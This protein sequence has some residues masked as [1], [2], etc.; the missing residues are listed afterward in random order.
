MNEIS[1]WLLKG[2][3]AIRYMAQRDLLGADAPTLAAL[4]SQIAFEG[5]G[6]A[7]LSRQNE[8]GHWGLHYYQ[9]KWTSTHYTL[10]DIKNLG[11][12]ATQRACVNIVARM[13]DECMDESGGLNLAKHEHLSD[14]CVDGMIL[15]YAAYFCPDDP[16]LAKLVD[17]LISAQKDDG[18]FTWEYK[19]ERGDPHTTICV[20]EGFGQYSASGSKYRASDIGDA[21]AKAVNYLL[22]NRLF[23]ED[24]DARFRKLTYPFRYRYDL[25]RALDYLAS[26]AIGFDER[27]RPALNWLLSKRD[28]DGRWHLENH[29]RGSVHFEMEELNAPSRFITLKALCI[30]KFYEPFI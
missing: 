16:R 19:S 28:E 9:P 20:L 8:D 29:H 15:S 22:A 21:M 18:G 2:D 24:S 23:I 11:M 17:H 13:F 25:L 3:A 6:A 1:R 12:P 14:T 7:F 5:F 30:L 27:M 26:H 4:Q 10:L